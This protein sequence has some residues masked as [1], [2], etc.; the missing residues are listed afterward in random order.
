[1][2]DDRERLA[3]SA[4]IRER[5]ENLTAPGFADVLAVVAVAVG[6]EL[7]M[8]ETTLLQLRR[9][10]YFGL[11]GVDVFPDDPRQQREFDAVAAAATE[12]AIVLRQQPPFE[13]IDATI[14]KT[15]KS[16]VMR[17]ALELV[18]ELITPLKVS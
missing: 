7:G 12:L 3:L 15:A 6:N 11:H 1:M 9:M 16:E 5:R 13:E 14:R 17:K 2:I 18:A 8:D 4:E 10:P